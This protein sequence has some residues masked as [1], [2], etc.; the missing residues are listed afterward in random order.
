MPGVQGSGFR[1]LVG[2][3]KEENA[4][5]DNEGQSM[6]CA[7]GRC[8]TSSLGNQRWTILIEQ[9]RRD[10]PEALSQ[11][12]HTSPALLKIDTPKHRVLIYS[13]SFWESSKSPPRLLQPSLPRPFS[14][15]TVFP[16]SDVTVLPPPPPSSSPRAQLSEDY[17]KQRGSPCARAPRCRRLRSSRAQREKGRYED[18]QY[19]LEEGRQSHGRLTVPG[20]SYTP[21]LLARK[22][23]SQ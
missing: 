17:P 2:E 14:L 1:N 7:M 15:R 23:D 10:V 3:R 19:T 9:K 4:Q 21:Q 5:R 13:E 11:T 8:P 16:C 22:P 12:K 18:G 6:H 20:V